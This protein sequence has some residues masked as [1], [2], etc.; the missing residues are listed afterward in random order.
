MQ[1][2]MK[3]L[4]IEIQQIEIRGNLRTRK[5]LFEN[6]L[7]DVMGSKKMKDLYDNLEKL[8]LRLREMDVFEG[9]DIKLDIAESNPS[10]YVAGIVVGV[11]ET[12]VPLLKV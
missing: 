3:D 4:P 6:E 8:N 10:K 11:K 7:D 12:S 2:F 9:V 5:S 1:A